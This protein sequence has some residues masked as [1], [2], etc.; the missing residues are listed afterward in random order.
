M[1]EFSYCGQTHIQTGIPIKF[2]NDQPVLH[3]GWR[4][5][6]YKNTTEQQAKQ[7]A[8]ADNRI[9]ISWFDMDSGEAVYG[10][11]EKERK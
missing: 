3:R 7:L 4:V 8:A 5:H 9:F 6:I 11:M 2:Q 1:A 10:G